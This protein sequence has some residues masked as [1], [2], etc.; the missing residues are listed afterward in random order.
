V[1]NCFKLQSNSINGGQETIEK[2]KTL[3]GKTYDNAAKCMSV[4]SDDKIYALN[5]GDCWNNNML[6]KLDPSSREI[7][8]HMFIDLQVRY[9][10]TLKTNE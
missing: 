1:S 3:V 9:N 6:F 8:D 4:N 2:L 10:Y 5:H 7:L